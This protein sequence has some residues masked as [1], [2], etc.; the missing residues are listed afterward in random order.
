MLS[1]TRIKQKGSDM[2]VVIHNKSSSVMVVGAETLH[3]PQYLYSATGIG[4]TEADLETAQREF[5]VRQPTPQLSIR[6]DT[7]AFAHRG[8]PRK[9][10]R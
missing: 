2:I 9:I 4:A 8:M 3:S 1:D 10:R 7:S 5:K 6:K